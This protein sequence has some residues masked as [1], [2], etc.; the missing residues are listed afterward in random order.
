MKK[1][2]LFTTILSFL[3]RLKRKMRLT[4]TRFIVLI[5]IGIILLGAV[6]LCLPA[7]S[8]NGQS[9][10]F[11]NAFF[12][13]TTATC[14]TG[15]VVVDTY[16]HWSLFGQL[17]ILCLIQMGGLGFMTFATL[18]SLFVGRTITM[19]ERLLMAESLNQ[20]KMVGI[21][22]LSKH[23]L[24]GTLMFESIGTLLFMMRFIPEFGFL[25]G[26]F[27][28]LFHSVSAF[29][30]AGIDVMGQK[31]AFSSF[32]AYSGDVIIN[33]GIMLLI[34][35]GGLGFGV[36]EDVLV[37]AR[38]M[39]RC[40]LH[41][42]LALVVTAVLLVIG[43]VLFF[44]FEY[45]N[46]ATMGNMPL[47]QKLMASLF[48]SVT[49]RTAGFNTIDIAAMTP[50][51]KLTTNILMFIGG[52]PGSTAG[53]I[54]TVT[55]AVLIFAVVA[56]VKGANDV[57]ISK[58][59]ITH[60]LVNRAVA[61]LMIGMIVV[62]VATLAIMAV[63]GFSFE[64]TLFECISAF[65]TVGLSTGITPHL[66]AFSKLVLIGLMIFGRVGVLTI[67]VAFAL[68]R[69]NGNEKFRY[70]EENVMVG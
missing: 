55:L 48:Q 25:N 3:L 12:T 9:I 1:N 70:P 11:L 14:V 13:A 26:I 40:R 63:D 20:N 61:V 17:V 46:P 5:F 57:N 31:E 2:Y 34:I 29:C 30:N 19:K 59:R 41:T 15:L 27:K 35:I 62:I 44:V 43:F 39:R 37:N 8:R 54:K 28:S 21:V 67:S 45:S 36:W 33:L 65:A 56:A 49:P 10:G 66:S 68:N 23:I 4:T 38:N 47:G 32:T 60:N 42:K 7:A 18:L 58:R 22:R 52:S 69:K 16:T 6:L 24:L 53:G 50:A 51:S 64:D